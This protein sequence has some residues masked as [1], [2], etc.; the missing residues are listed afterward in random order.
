VKLK[1]GCK[2]ILEHKEWSANGVYWALHLKVQL[3]KSLT[4]L[5]LMKNEIHVQ[6]PFSALTFVV[7]GTKDCKLLEGVEQKQRMS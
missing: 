4:K 3:L 6:Q 7:M 2:G 1:D 5:A